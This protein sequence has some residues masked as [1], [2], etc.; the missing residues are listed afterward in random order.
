MI[1]IVVYAP[2]WMLGWLSK[3]RRRPAERAMR[4]WPLVAVL[5][6][7]AFVGI[8]ILCGDDLIE[9]LGNLTGWSFSLFLATLAYAVAAIG[10]AVAVWR[11]PQEGVR[12]RVRRFSQI[13]TVALLIAAAY[14]GYWGIIGLRT[15]A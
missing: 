8:F 10:S 5:S 1:A 15:W 4:I 14:L 9:R 6:L 2:F 3:K 12:R 7:A 13:V 11:A